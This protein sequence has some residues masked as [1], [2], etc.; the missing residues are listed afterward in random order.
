VSRC[1]GCRRASLAEDS[2]GTYFVA[3][4]SARYVNQA[5]VTSALSTA[6]SPFPQSSAAAA[7][8]NATVQSLVNLYSTDPSLG[9]PYNTGSQTFLLPPLYK[10]L[11]AIGTSKFRFAARQRTDLIDTA[12]D[13]TFHAARRALQ[14]ASISNGIPSFG[15]IFAEPQPEAP[16]MLGVTHGQDQPYPYSLCQGLSST[17]PALTMAINDYFL[18]FA[19]SLTP[20]DAHGVT[21]RLSWPAYTKSNPVRASSF[22]LA[23]VTLITTPASAQQLLQIGGL[24][25]ATVIPDTYRAQQI[26]FIQKNAAVF[27]F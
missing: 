3:G 18:S 2:A 8:V 17:C 22:S 9:S 21:K 13:I 19:S 4:T 7:S 5:A 14:Q 20:N 6:Y 12:G 1:A 10:Q 24:T 27:H 11:A 25:P 15:Y 26:A 16:T 23:N